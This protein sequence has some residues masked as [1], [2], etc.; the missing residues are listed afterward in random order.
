MMQA[1]ATLSQ[2]TLNPKINA[3]TPDAADVADVKASIKAKGWIGTMWVREITRR[4]EAGLPVYDIIDG[5]RRWYALHE[6][7]AEN[8]WR[9]DQD[10]AITVFNVNDA[11]A[12]EL[13]TLSVEVRRDL[14]PADQCTTFY[15]LKLNGMTEA[16]I[17]SHFAVSEKLVRQRLTLGALPSVIITALRLGDMDL[18][19]A[20][21]FTLA[22]SAERQLQVFEKLAKT[23]WSAYAVRS[24]LL[25]KSISAD[26]FKCKFVGAEEYQAAGGTITTDL[27]SENRHFDDGAL[28]HKLFDAKIEATAQALKDEGWQWVEIVKGGGHKLASYGLQKPKG[29]KHLNTEEYL[30][31]GACKVRLAGLEA[32]D[33]DSEDWNAER[34]EEFEALVQEVKA[35]ETP[36]FTERQMQKAG[37]A[38]VIKEWQPVEI[39]RGLLK[40]SKSKASASEPEAE[41]DPEAPAAPAPVIESID[42]SDTVLDLLT[43]TACHA[44]KLAMVTQ[45]PRMAYRMGLAAR[46]MAFFKRSH[47]APFIVSHRP[48]GGGLALGVLLAEIADSNLSFIDLVA[49]L[50]TGEDKHI[51][52]LEAALAADTLQFTS[53]KNTDVQAVIQVLDPDMQAEGFKPDAAFLSLLSRAKIEAIL[54]EIDPN[55]PALKSRKKTDLVAHAVPQIEMHGWLP[56]PLRTPSYKGPGSAQW[57]E[58]L[59]AKLVHEAEEAREPTAEEAAA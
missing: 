3:R 41:D 43:Q 25:E 33:Q 20:M 30:R 39:H 23:G 32:I 38:I 56:A 18:A 34:D 37:C 15:R 51:L 24:E 44:T 9:V 19:S 40:P 59:A 26:H 52:Y 55:R 46:V 45:Y 29:T 36:P 8:N 42:Y 10:I 2:L 49:M 22:G 14:S 47:E 58:A 57:Q 35:L 12:L 16:D 6:L 48:S 7:Q 31:R 28:V 11:E 53:L 5:S 4:T 1:S 13:S 21:A 54:D 27:F 17:A 50:E